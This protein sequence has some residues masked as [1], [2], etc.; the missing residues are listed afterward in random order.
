M[1]KFYW[2]VETLFRVISY[3]YKKVIW[4]IALFN[5]SRR[6]LISLMRSTREFHENWDS[7]HLC[8]HNFYSIN[9]WLFIAILLLGKIRTWNKCIS[10][11]NMVFCFL[12]CLFSSCFVCFFLLFKS[13][14]VIITNSI[15]WNNICLKI[16]LALN[17]W[18]IKIE[19]MIWSKKHCFFNYVDS[20]LFARN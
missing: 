16:W 1:L 15:N 6:M 7:I 8:W 4:L 10:L 18:L 17:N 2:F 14:D 5:N 11:Q 9:F 12:F 3:I 13:K 19:K 20:L